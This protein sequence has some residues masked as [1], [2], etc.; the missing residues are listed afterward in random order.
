M[1]D[2]RTDY[3]MPM[4]M[5][6]GGIEHA[7]L[8]LL[9][10]R[11]WAKACRDL[12]LIKFGEPAANLLTQG[13]VL[14]STY[15]REDSTGKRTWFNPLDISTTADGATLK[16]DG[17]PVVSGGVEKM[18]KSKNN[19]VDPQS[20]IDVYGADTAR[21]F[22]MFAAPPE[23]SLEWADSGVE[24]ASRFLRRLW[25]FGFTQHDVLKAG[26]VDRA[27]LRAATLT[28][29]QKALRLD[30]H[31]VLKQAE[32][33]YQRIQYNT[34]VSAGM[35]MLNALDA[36]KSA[37]EGEHGAS[38]LR[39]CYGILLQLLYP[40]VPHITVTLWDALGYRDEFGTD[41]LDTPWQGV[42]DKAL[43]VSEIELVLQ[44]NG[45]VRGALTVAKD[46]TREVIEKAALA[47]EMFER[48]GN[49]QTAKK[50]IVVPGRLVN[51]VV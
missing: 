2:A 9:Y 41:L 33:D 17:Q 49:G 35:K 19:G 11:F 24:G 23:Q 48:F 45:K 15:Y 3:W 4:D 18:S 38:V 16:S 8:H 36:A 13:M 31:T 6:I 51:V 1:V 25:N 22:T 29:A 30:I 7:I 12:G 14:N 10:S 32:F 50:V 34:V 43:D 37:A 46:A 39:E 5:Y 28:D 21:L 44:I 20:L 47:H 42:D 40:V 26:R 27:A